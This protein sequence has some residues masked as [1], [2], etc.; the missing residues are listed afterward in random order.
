MP[1]DSRVPFR[2][3]GRVQEEANSPL[4]GPLTLADGG[5]VLPPDDRLLPYARI[6]GIA[7]ADYRIELTLAG[8]GSFFLSQLGY[9]YEDFVRELRRR[10]EPFRLRQ[11]LAPASDR[12]LLD[13][14]AG[15]LWPA[16]GPPAER[17]GALRLGETLLSWIPAQGPL[18]LVP[19]AAITTIETREWKL[20]LL[21]D[22]GGRLEFHHLG[23]RL[24]PL[25]REIALERD[26]LRQT[27]R[28]QLARLLEGLPE[29]AIEEASILL[30]DGRAVFLSDLTARLPQ[31]WDTL[32]RRLRENRGADELAAALAQGHPEAA[33]IGLKRGLLGSLTGTDLFLLVPYWGETT[34]DPGNAVGFASLTLSPSADGTGG[35]R[36]ELFFRLAERAD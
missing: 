28:V 29:E 15:T 18:T 8:G 36:A 20:H 16:G 7:A 4:T 17:S 23:D 25:R 12:L 24:D 10:W 34:A 35:G 26:G 30:A 1:P 2:C 31:V 21:F 14:V 32:Q 22:D 33:M 5:I 9:L 6:E 19:L 11:H 13:D 27:N 3:D